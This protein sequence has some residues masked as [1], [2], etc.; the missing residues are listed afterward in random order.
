MLTLCCRSADKLELR[1]HNVSICCYAAAVA[2][3]CQ[4]YC[5]TPLGGL[6]GNPGISRKRMQVAQGKC[7][8]TP[9]DDG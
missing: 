2:L 4:H 1:Q 5:N 6:V 9:A 3:A 8:D 7:A